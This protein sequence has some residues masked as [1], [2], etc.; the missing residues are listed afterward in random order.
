VKN[1]RH[2]RLKFFFSLFLLS[3]ALKKP[4]DKIKG[5]TQNHALSL[6]NGPLTF[7]CFKALP[8]SG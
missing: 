7:L 3:R 4:A 2:Q 8:H 1:L 6:P 5:L